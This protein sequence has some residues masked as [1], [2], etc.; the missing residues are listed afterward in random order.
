MFQMC[1]AKL[2]R[3]GCSY[4]APFTHAPVASERD[5]ASDRE[6]V[7]AVVQWSCHLQEMKVGRE[8]NIDEISKH[9]VKRWYLLC[10]VHRNVRKELLVNV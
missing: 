7:L 3:V 4:D 5:Q 2:V 9:A 1:N 8:T 10:L 6:Y